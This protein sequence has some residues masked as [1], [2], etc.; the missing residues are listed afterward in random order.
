MIDV[1]VDSE[2]DILACGNGKGVVGEVL[3]TI[4]IAA[5]VGAGNIGHGVVGVRSCPVSNI[6]PV[7]GCGA[8]IDQC[9]EG[10]VGRCRTSE[11]EDRSER[12]HTSAIPGV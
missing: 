12:F 2:P 10:V 3:V 5:D 8:S 9:W 6:L 7:G 4:D 1:W 11:G